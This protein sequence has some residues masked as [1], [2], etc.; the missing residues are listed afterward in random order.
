MT[1]QAV[2]GMSFAMVGGGG[3]DALTER[4]GS[5]AAGQTA[6]GLL[7]VG[8]AGALTTGDVTVVRHAL[9]GWGVTT[10]VIPDPAGLPRYEQ[11][12][13][14]RTTVVLMTAAIGRAPERRAGAWVWT[15]VDRA[16]PP[17]ASSAVGDCVQGPEDGTVASIDHSV[18]CAL[19]GRTA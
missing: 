2:D 6:I 10:V 16:G 19:S 8:G 17:V 3:P 4:A 5:E 1:W 7:S 9:D 15:G 12:P 14:V 11:L 13:Q 18:A